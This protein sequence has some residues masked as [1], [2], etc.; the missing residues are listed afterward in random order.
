MIW[1]NG[2]KPGDY[3]YIGGFPHFVADAGED[4][5][6][7]WLDEKSPSGGWVRFSPPRRTFHRRPC[8]SNTPVPVR[9]LT[10]GVPRSGPPEPLR[11]MLPT[12]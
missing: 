9:E 12:V 6:G 1:G 2:L 8:W 11:I 10:R 3:K 7:R 5:V 4:R